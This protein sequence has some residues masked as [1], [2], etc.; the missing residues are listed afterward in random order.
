MITIGSVRSV[1]HV[2]N[3]T[4]KPDDRQSLVQTIG[5]V[6]VEDYGVVDNGEVLSMTATFDSTNYDALV[7]LWK[8]RTLS[9]VT[10]EDGSVIT[11]RVVIRSYTYADKLFP[12]YKKVSFELWRV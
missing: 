4:S 2:E 1:G 11:A 3:Y 12:G 8:N 9:S 6:V 10:L 5:G 7:L